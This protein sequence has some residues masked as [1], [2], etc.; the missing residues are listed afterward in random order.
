VPREVRVILRAFRATATEDGADAY[1]RF[2][3]DSVLPVLQGIDGFQGAYVT[4]RDREDH[5]QI[6]VL[7]LWESLDAIS[8]FAG[9]NLHAAVVE[10]GARAVLTDFDPVVTHHT[11]VVSS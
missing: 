9:D 11:V 5:V 1:Q 4:R 6:Q 10:P 7:T 2:F 8:R 3:V